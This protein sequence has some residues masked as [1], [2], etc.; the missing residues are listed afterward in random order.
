MND[1]DIQTKV[2]SIDRRL[3]VLKTK[4][5]DPITSELIDV[6]QDQNQFI[7]NALTNVLKVLHTLQKDEENH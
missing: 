7:L 6:I 5:P 1:K 4:L 3:R 2:S